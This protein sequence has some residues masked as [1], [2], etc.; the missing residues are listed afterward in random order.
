MNEDKRTVE[1]AI[2]TELTEVLSHLVVRYRLAEDLVIAPKESPIVLRK[3]KVLSERLHC[4]MSLV[5]ALALDVPPLKGKKVLDV[6]TGVGAAALAF[7]F[8]QA[9][10][11]AIDVDTKFLS[12]AD[13][14]LSLAKTKAASRN[15][16]LGRVQFYKISAESLAFPNSVFDFIVC[17]DVL[18]HVPCP[19]RTLKEIYRVLKPGGTLLIRQGFALNPHFLRRDPH[20]GLPLVTL[21]PEL[22]RAVI[23]VQLVGRCHRVRDKKWPFTHNHLRRW[24]GKSGRYRVLRWQKDG[25]QKGWLGFLLARTA[26]SSLLLEKLGRT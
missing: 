15:L 10:V 12:V 14:F 18:E 21:M 16:L 4:F 5:E 1:P 22:L 25:A 6:G 3:N 13:E 19:I 17:S 20:Y 26:Y 24:L 8:Y 11:F 2:V 9:D 7:A 23:V